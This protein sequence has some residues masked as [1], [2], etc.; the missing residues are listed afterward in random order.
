MSIQNRTRLTHGL[1]VTG[2]VFS[3]ACLCTISASIRAQEKG[4]ATPDLNGVLP[5]MPYDLY[6]EEFVTL[7]DSWNSWSV[8]VAAEVTK[9]YEED[10][11]AAAQR[12]SLATLQIKLGTMRKALAD[13]R[14]RIIYDPL[15]TMHGRLSRRVDV[16]EAALDTLE[17]DPTTAHSAR[18]ASAQQD[19]AAK[20][21]ALEVW[22]KEIKGGSKWIGYMKLDQ[23]A[24]ADADVAVMSS[25]QAKITK[26]GMLKNQKQRSFMQRPPFQT[27]GKS[28][29]KRIAAVQAPVPTSNKAKLRESVTALLG[30]LEAY[31]ENSISQNTAAIHKALAAVK[32]LAA[33]NGDRLQAAVDNHYMNFNIRVVAT[34]RFMNKMVSYQHTDQSPVNDFILGA[35]VDGP[36]T[37]RGT[38][39]IDLRPSDDT[40]R[41]LMTIDG[42][43]RSRTQ[44]VTD[45]A[46]IFTSGYHTFKATKNVT[47]D[48]DV[49]KTKPAGISVNA[50][51]RTLDARTKY[52]GVPLFGGLTNSYAMREARKRKGQSEAIARQKLSAKVLPE[53]NQQIDKEFKKLTASLTNTVIPKLHDVDAFPAKRGYLSTDDELWSSALLMGSGEIGGNSPV[54]MTTTSKGM[55][56]H[57]HESAINNAL[58]R[59]SFGGQTLTDA[60]LVREVGNSLGAF[61]GKDINFE[62][63]GEPDPTKFVFPKSDV[64][65]AKINNGQLILSLRAGLKTEDDDI[66]TQIISIPLMFEIKG[67][68]I[69]VSAG[70]VGVLPAAPPKSRVKQKVQ[71]GV[72]ETKV[73]KA[74]PTR[75]VDRFITVKRN[76]GGPVKLAITQIKPMAGWL[77]IVVE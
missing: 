34:E 70:K 21:K 7:G 3:V 25:I 46:T 64:L 44:G 53:F 19:V 14:Y 8:G 65:R 61:L 63:K 11:D 9:L 1:L 47:F 26:A 31:E 69:V 71:A 54:F 36:Q 39:G 51:N 4:A 77:S 32:G 23:L 73:Q 38:V 24:K 12:A 15:M 22:L 56:L 37:T 5:E 10:L 29:A 30:A 16:V 59:F 60:E 28:L 18:L 66:A 17:L 42:V 62:L 27:L 45:Q 48:G 68:E 75:T 6:E 35:K 67:S 43:T 57:L 50:S 41:F 49:F 2:V 13:S 74:L 33:D 40:I 55:V 58:A 20:S 52:S 72:V 76:Q